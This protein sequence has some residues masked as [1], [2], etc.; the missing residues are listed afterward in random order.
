MGVL[1]SL[2]R[3]GGAYEPHRCGSREP[4]F[5]T[6]TVLKVLGPPQIHPPARHGVARSNLVNLLT[7]FHAAPVAAKGFGAVFAGTLFC[8]Y[9]RSS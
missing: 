4:L 5:I 1:S 9:D 8:G 2:G 6:L 3:V 7:L